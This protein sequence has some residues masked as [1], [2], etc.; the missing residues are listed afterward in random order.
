VSLHP[1]HEIQTL[2]VRLADGD[3]TAFEPLYRALW[4]IVRRFADKLLSGSP[5]AEDAAQSAMLKVFARASQFDPER[6]AL[7]W[8]LAV[9]AYE[10][11]TLRKTNARR[12]EQPLD[13]ASSF[14]DSSASPEAAAI[15]RELEAA[16]LEVLGTLRP[17]DLDTLRDVLSG[18]RP[19]LPQPTF[20]KRVERAFTRLRTAWSSRH[21][22]D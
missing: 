17:A 2:M 4:P 16:A 19:P 8:V 20:R 1:Q 7:T 18:D 22:L 6:S 3:R 12:R 15:A 10:C 14:V 21:G 5:D 9:T 11:R 13:T